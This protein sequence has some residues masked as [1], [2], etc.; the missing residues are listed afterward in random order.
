[1]LILFNFLFILLNITYICIIKFK[2]WQK[3]IKLQALKSSLVI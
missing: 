2:K 1:M 3:K